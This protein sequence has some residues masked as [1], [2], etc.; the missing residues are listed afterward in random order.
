[1]DGARHDLMN[2]M[3]EVQNGVVKWKWKCTTE[4]TEESLKQL[5]Y[6]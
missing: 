1:M 5:Q 4:L 3:R 6:L 2:D